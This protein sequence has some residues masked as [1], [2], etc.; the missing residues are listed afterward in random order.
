MIPAAWIGQE[1]RAR[2]V[3]NAPVVAPTNDAIADRLLSYS[4]LLDLADA[5]PYASR[6]YRRAAEIV[7]TTPA[8]V[9]ALVRQGR[10]RELRGIGPGIERRLRELVETGDIAELRELEDELNPELVGLGRLLG[11]SSR[12]VLEIGK[13]L[14]VRTAADLRA[15]AESGKL[16][17][18]PGVGKTTESRIL[19]ALAAPL[20]APRGLTVNGSRPL[21]WRPAFPAGRHDV[22]VV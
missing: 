16:T 12:R 1:T 19:T 17:S 14:D 18:V 11:L 13:A 9:A 21:P 6:A 15:A 5:S 3:R 7:R 4:A 22:L 8:P 20:R 10:L 2:P